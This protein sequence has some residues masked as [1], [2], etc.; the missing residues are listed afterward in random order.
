MKANDLRP[1][2]IVIFEGDQYRVAEAS[3][4]SPGNKR[5]FIQVRLMRLKDGIQREYKFSSTE[6]VEKVVLE[7]H[8]MQFLYQEQGHYHFMDVENYEQMSIDGTQLGNGAHY[9]L[10]NAVVHM[11]FF[12]NKPTGIDLPSSLDFLVIDAEPGIGTA[13]ASASYKNAKIETGHTIKVPQFVEVGD[14]IKVNP[15]TDEY[16][17]RSKGK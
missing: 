17:E 10:P 14:R 3:H 8:E 6:E 5:A 11:T 12:E 9:L 15:N 1:G 7:T 16:L 13:T 2:H 4:R